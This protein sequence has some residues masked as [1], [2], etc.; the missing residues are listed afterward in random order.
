[1]AYAQWVSFTIKTVGFSATT[2]YC[3]L[4]WGKW[5]KWDNKDDEI[6]SVNG[7]TLDKGKTYN[8]I[9]SSCGRSDSSSGTEGSFYLCDGS[10]KQGDPDYK[11]CKLSWDCP[12]GSKTNTWAASDYDSD[13]YIVSITGGSSYG[14]A[15]G[16]L[17]V[18]VAKIA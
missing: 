18:T 2:D 3:G 11:I 8:N 6:G 14:G 15:I 16:T 17:T 13:Q 5:Y 4:D 12:W 1:M 9:I 7:I 10:K